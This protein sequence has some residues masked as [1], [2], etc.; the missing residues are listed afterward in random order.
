MRLRPAMTSLLLLAVPAF[1]GGPSAPSLPRPL[2]VPTAGLDPDWAA[3]A[4]WS[5]WRAGGGSPAPLAL[6]PS[7]SGDWRVG[8]VPDSGAGSAEW[9]VLGEADGRAATLVARSGEMPA[10]A[11][12]ILAPSLGVTPRAGA[13]DLD[14]AASD[15][16]GLIAWRVQSTADGRAWT[17]AGADAAPSDA[18]LAVAMPQGAFSWRLV[19]VLE[20]GV[21]PAT[22]GAAS[23]TARVSDGDL[24]D[25]G[26]DDASDRCGVFADP[27]QEDQDR[28]GISDACELAWGDIAPRGRTDGAVGIGDVVVMLRFAVGLDAPTPRE[29]RAADVAPAVV[30][31]GNP[32]HATPRLQA[33]AAIAVDDAVLALRASVGLL[34]F[35]DPR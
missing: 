34:R 24:D 5:A 15:A 4:T 1:A 10:P 23:A 18:A 2:L 27:G 30:L 22:A 11:E 16:P 3:G 13:V 19:P 12:E 29:L 8:T 31:R 32:D 25:D 35:A 7:S 6:Q 17:D 14:W 9:I 33:P 21:V 26:V 20:G 28:D